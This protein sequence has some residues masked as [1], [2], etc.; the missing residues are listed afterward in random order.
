MSTKN[1][2]STTIDHLPFGPRPG[3]G[4]M[5]MMTGSI[6]TVKNRRGLVR[7]LWGYLNRYRLGLFGITSMVII[8]SLLSLACPYLMGRAIDKYISVGDLPGLARTVLL[9]LLVYIITSIAMWVQSVAM[10]RI[11]QH[12]V[13]DIRKDLF[14]KLQTLSLSY[15][16][17]H[18]H[19]E[20]MSRL[21]ND[22]DTISATLGDLF[23]QMIGSLL[24]VFGAGAIMFALNWRMAIATLI[25]FPLVLLATRWIGGHTRQGFRDRQ[26][27]LGELNGIVEETLIGQRVIKVCRR[28]PEAIR[29]FSIANAELN[30][31]AISA[32][33]YAGLMGPV[34]GVFRNMGFAILACT[35]G[36]LAV[37]GFVTIGTVA[38]FM[39]YA[40]YFNRP[41]YQL[42]GLY[43]SV[44][45]ALAGA[46]RIFAVIDESH[47]LEEAAD[48]QPLTDVRG[49]V[50]FDKVSFGYV[51]DVPVLTEVSFHALPGQTIA[52]VGSTGAG[53]TTIVNLLTRFYDIDKGVIRIDGRDVC[54]LGKNNLR[55]MLGIV[56][57]D[58]VLFTGS[59]RD[60]IR[61]GR[62]D[63]TDEEIV[64]AARLS[65]ADSFINHLSHGYDTV[66][67]DSGNSLSTGQRQLLAIARTMLADPAILI[68]DEATSS[69][70]TRTEIHIQEAMRRLMHGR[71]SFIIAHRLG[72]IRQADCILVIEHGKIVERGTH[73]EL[74]AKKGVYQNLVAS[75]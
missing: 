20:L 6:P 9:L 67:T 65:N 11:A 29:I 75:S 40:D 74:L 15:F 34:M 70:D 38:A 22:P 21:T 46:E 49:D 68:L 55:R 59:V 66:L 16:D 52:L 35:G 73:E 7:R 28:E 62:L 57:Q 64:G 54:T 19:G 39:N 25:T 72:T 45:S 71:T 2:Q 30:K 50:Q 31:A 42:A 17:R 3:R 33:I 37:Q 18:P 14:E 48:A 4:P 53:K 13:C 47:E 32:T 51:P 8:T 5:G 56:L 58:T 36:W 69:V 27:K 24:S 60:N 10:I 1:R 26:K 61:Y 41:L 44:Q 63:A 23:T 43:G 12:T